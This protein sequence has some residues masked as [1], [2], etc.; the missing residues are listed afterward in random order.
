MYSQWRVSAYSVSVSWKC[1]ASTMLRVVR[2]TTTAASAMPCV[3][4]DTGNSDCDSLMAHLA[5]WSILDSPRSGKLPDSSGK[6]S[7][8]GCV[9]FAETTPSQKNKEGCCDPTVHRRGFY[10]L[11]NC[12]L[13]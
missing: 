4:C 7:L 13:A 12:A 11:C 1:V 9:A 3:S 6:R 8:V 10:M 5:A 2:P